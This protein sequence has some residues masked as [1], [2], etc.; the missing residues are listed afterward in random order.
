MVLL[1][2]LSPWAAL[3]FQ[4]AGALPPLQDVSNNKSAKVKDKILIVL[5]FTG[6]SSFI[7]Y[8]HP[9]KMQFLCQGKK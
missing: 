2:L 5:L 9:D 8:S 3:L 6:F 1:S 7:F 4:L